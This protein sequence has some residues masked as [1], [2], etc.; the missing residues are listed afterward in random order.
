MLLGRPNLWSKSI[1]TQHT[2]AKSSTCAGGAAKSNRRAAPSGMDAKA[3]GPLRQTPFRGPRRRLHMTMIWGSLLFV[4]RAWTQLASAILLLT[5]ARVL[6]PADVGVFSLASALVMVLTQWVGVGTYEYVIRERDDPASVPTALWSNLVVACV[7]MGVGF[8]LA[9][10]AGP[11]FHAPAPPP[12][13]SG[14]VTV[15]VACSLAFG[16]GRTSRAQW[17][18]PAAFSLHVDCRSDRSCRGT[19]R[20]VARQ[21]ALGSCHP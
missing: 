18:R 11:V 3:A 7:F 9:A 4:S 19:D 1:T 14:A 16:D 20:V 12:G 21:R 6:S 17:R 10:V 15:D 8:A 2:Y 5:S 13:R